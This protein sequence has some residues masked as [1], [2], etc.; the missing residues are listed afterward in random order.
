MNYLLYIFLFSAFSFCFHPSY[1]NSENINNPPQNSSDVETINV[2]QKDDIIA[3]G[4]SF[5]LPG[6]GQFYKKKWKRGAV[7][8][9]ME[10]IL[11]NYHNNYNEKGDYYVNKYKEFANSHWDLK[12]WVENYYSYIDPNDPIHSTMIND[13]TC[14]QNGSYQ[15]SNGYNGYCAPW[16][17]AHFIEFINP[18]GNTINTRDSAALNQLF[19]DVCD[20][21][22]NY[23]I[24][25][26]TIS[27]GDYF[28]N[29]IV[30]K[31][32]HFYEGIGKYNLFFAGWDDTFECM[33]EENGNL[34][35]ST[36]CRWISY[37]N[38]YEVA[39]S[40][41]KQFYQNQLRKKSNNRYDYAE[42]ALSLIFVNHFVSMFDVFLSDLLN[43]DR[44]N[45]HNIS[46]YSNSQK[47]IDGIK[48]RIA[49]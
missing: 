12:N 9:G 25:G 4:L 23:Y 24:N 11:W 3:M 33:D 19:I 7:Y 43:Y 47:N 8:F 31:D 42:N 22:T 2:F 16:Y 26:C 36:D 44:E 46:F 21:G 15:N 13:A 30:T 38:E 40:S 14:N 17:S 5:I 41:N 35:T 10:F 32:H 34:V 37:N 28:Q 49:W 6:S 18:Q 48:V 20:E 29:Y 39:L 1:K 27:D 45:L